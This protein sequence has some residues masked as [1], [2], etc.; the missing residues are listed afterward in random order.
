MVIYTN[1]AANCEQFEQA[2]ET[3]SNWFRKYGMKF[4]LEKSE[5]LHFSRAYKACLLFVRLSNTAISPVNFARF[6]GVWLDRKLSWKAHI[7]KVK[8]KITTQMLAFSKLAALAW[9]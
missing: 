4:A 7:A 8:R 5:L 2:W 9:G 1:F 6:L 3:C